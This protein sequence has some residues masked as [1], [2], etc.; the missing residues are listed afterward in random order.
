MKNFIGFISYKKAR[1][2]ATA[3]CKIYRV[4]RNKLVYLGEEKWNTGATKGE[5]SEIMDFLSFNGYIPKKNKGYYEE[6]G[7]NF[8]IDY[9]ESI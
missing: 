8:I 4:K 9:I 6:N 5:K 7:G 1:Y 3:K 2:C